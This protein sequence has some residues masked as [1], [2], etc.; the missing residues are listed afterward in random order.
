MNFVEW[1][2]FRSLVWERSERKIRPRPVLN[3]LHVRHLAESPAREESVVWRNSG[4]GHAMKSARLIRKSS[5]KAGISVLKL[6]VVAISAIG[7]FAL[8]VIVVALTSGFPLP[9]TVLGQSPFGDFLVP[10]N[11]FADVTSPAYNESLLRSGTDYLF[12]G[13]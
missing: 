6:T 7:L 4:S 5:I 13:F 8:I 3:Q 11:S 10:G 2:D 1:S 9:G 12:P